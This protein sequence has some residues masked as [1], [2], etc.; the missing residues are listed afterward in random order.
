MKPLTIVI[1]N[2]AGE[3]PLIT[4]RSL[5]EQDFTDFDVV[6]VNDHEGNANIARNRGMECVDTEFVLFC[7][8]DIEWMPGILRLMLKTLNENK[9]ISYVWGSYEMEGMIQ[10]YEDYNPIRLREKNFISTMAMVRTVHHP[11]FDPSVKRFQDWDVWL[12]MLENGH[13]G[14]NIGKLAFKTELRTTGITYGGKVSLN[15]ALNYINNKHGL[16]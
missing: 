8:N 5:Y 12:T 10:C 11:G 7:D 1:P 15:D 6:I 2:K 9:N 16:R 14:K 4:I 3:N 13:I